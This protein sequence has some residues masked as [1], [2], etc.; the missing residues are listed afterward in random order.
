MS[1]LCETCYSTVP[2]L[3]VL[4]GYLEKLCW[5]YE[6]TELN[7]G[8]LRMELVCMRAHT[9]FKDFIFMLCDV[10]LYK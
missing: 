4:F 1:Y 6:Q 2:Y 3:V 10:T 5:I 7:K 9:I 8:I